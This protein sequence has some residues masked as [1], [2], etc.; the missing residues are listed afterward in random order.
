MKK[1][2]AA[3]QKTSSV[4]QTEK[5]L[6]VMHIKPMRYWVAYAI[7]VMIYENTRAR[8]DRHDVANP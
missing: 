1:E 3:I 5:P 6:S 2:A 8:R 4:G 7:S